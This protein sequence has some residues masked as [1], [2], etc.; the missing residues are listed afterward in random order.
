MSTLIGVEY[1][2]ATVA[3][4]TLTLADLHADQTIE[5][6]RIQ[7]VDNHNT[8]RY[9]VLPK[10]HFTALL[11]S[12]RPSISITKSVLGLVFLTLASGFGPA[13]EYLYVFDL[14]SIRRCA[15]AEGHAVLFG[16]FQE[17]LPVGLPPTVDVPICPRTTLARIV[18]DAKTSLNAAF[19][20]GVETEFILLSSTAPPTA[21]NKHGW[22]NS[23]ALPSGTPAAAV[24]H[25]IAQALI[26]GG[27]ELQMYHSEAAPGQYEII[28]GPLAPLEAADA[29]VHTRETIFNVASKH[30]MRATLAPRLYTDSCGSAS[31]THLSVHPAAP[32]SGPSPASTAHPALLTHLESTF[33]A[34]LLAHLPAALALTL[35]TR[36]SYARMRDGIWS[37]G[38][39][40]AWGPDNREVP[41]R[42]CNAHS[43][44]SRNFEVKSADGTASPY[45]AIAALVGAGAAGVRAGREVEGAMWDRGELLAEVG[46]AERRA[47]GVVGRLPVTLEE[48]RK[49]LDA[50]VG[51]REVLGDA[52]VDA[53]FAVNETL[54]KIMSEGTEEEIVTRL[55]ENF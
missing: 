11:A 2:P 14:D 16:W 1:T 50:D 53:F 43:P 28:T 39:Y 23:T 51:M 21:I 4:R 29:L 5:Y 42:L 26:A 24:L 6:V 27:I 47:A 25:E 52:L 9:R 46:E 17:K 3:P 55:V 15:Y 31:H 19:L 22:S 36:A 38:T 40:V 33:L 34:G 49:C 7:W 44:R 41:V 10:A 54:D 37:G 13:G 32:G 8:I 48:A 20:V 18:K 30:G 35:P 45:L 12:P